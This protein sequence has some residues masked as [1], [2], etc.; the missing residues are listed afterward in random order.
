MCESLAL[1]V[2]GIGVDALQHSCEFAKPDSKTITYI[3][4]INAAASCFITT[5]LTI[6]AMVEGDV[7]LRTG[8]DNE[9]PIGKIIS[10]RPENNEIHTG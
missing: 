4:E 7:D 1:R 5:F 8:T 9:D 2:I 6:F 10:A 3:T